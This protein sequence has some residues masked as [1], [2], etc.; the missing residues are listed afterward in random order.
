MQ[1]P[2]C[3]R[4]HRT[5]RYPELEGTHKEDR[6]HLLAPQRFTP[7]SNPIS[8]CWPNILCASSGLVPWLLP[9]EPVVVPSH[10]LVKS[11]LS[12]PNLTLPWH[13]S[14]H[15][16]RSH[17]CLQR[18]DL[19]LACPCYCREDP[20]TAPVISRI[21]PWIQELIKHRV[22]RKKGELHH[23][24]QTPWSQWCSCTAFPT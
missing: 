6:V 16:L 11:L 12:I 10:S 9:W 24:S 18:I 2:W 5:I 1:V 21:I 23:C 8:E 20:F 3:K 15:S 13:S 14:T 19:C 4:N 7:N 22:I 17:H